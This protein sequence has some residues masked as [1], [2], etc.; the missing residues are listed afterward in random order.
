MESNINW[1]SRYDNLQ[2]ACMK[3]RA[4]LQAK[5]ERYKAALKE[6]RYVHK[7][8]DSSAA[9]RLSQAQNIAIQA[10]SAGEGERF[11]ETDAKFMK[12]CNLHLLT[13][14]GAIIQTENDEGARLTKDDLLRLSSILY[15]YVNQ[16]EDQQ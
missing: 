7:S 15:R 14:G 1:Q 5:C 16:K 3:E 2:E 13:D 11:T 4:A 9:W 6:I 12:E 10:L 8:S